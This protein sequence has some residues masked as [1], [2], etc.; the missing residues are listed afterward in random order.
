MTALSGDAYDIMQD[1]VILD[2][3]TGYAVQICHGF[4]ING[5]YTCVGGTFT[6]NT[7]LNADRGVVLFYGS[8]VDDYYTVTNNI[9][10][11]ITASNY[12]GILIHGGNCGSHNVLPS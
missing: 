6:N 11:N 2:H 7:I 3:G 8:V 5:V 12:A 1:N 4:P 9:I 10:G